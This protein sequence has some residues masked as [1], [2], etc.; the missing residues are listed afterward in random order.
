MNRDNVKPQRPP[1][2]Q[3]E[4]LVSAMDICVL[5]G[6]TVPEGRWVCPACER[7]AEKGGFDASAAFV[8]KEERF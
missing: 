1:S 2:V 3:G 5:C 6:N 7:D 8:S 4:I